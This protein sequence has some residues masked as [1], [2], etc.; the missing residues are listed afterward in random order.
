M[1]KFNIILKESFKRGHFKTGN[2]VAMS[3]FIIDENMEVRALGEEDDF[4]C[5]NSRF[6]L[7]GHFPS[8]LNSFDHKDSFLSYL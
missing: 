7:N 4:F 2:K 8:K 1:N 6:D 3:S 5:D